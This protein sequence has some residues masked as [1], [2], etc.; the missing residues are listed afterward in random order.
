M[1]SD[2]KMPAPSQCFVHKP[3]EKRQLEHCIEKAML[4]L[5]SK[6]MFGGIMITYNAPGFPL[7]YI[8]EQMLSLLNYPSQT[9]L[10]AAVGK[11]MI[12]CL[13]PEDRENVKAEIAQALLV[14]NNYT[15]AYRMLCR[16][17]GLY[18]GKRDRSTDGL[19]QWRI[20]TGQPML[21]HHRSNGG[22]G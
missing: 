20:S 5:L 9:D 17:K 12:N 11:A 3:D 8:D 6:C 7:Y 22:A 1:K 4:D 14:G 10:I 19:T 15:T 16:G 13:R 21:G 18:L 2:L